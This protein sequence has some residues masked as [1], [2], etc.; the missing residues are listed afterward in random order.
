MWGSE[1]S[2]VSESSGDSRFNRVS[3]TLSIL[4]FW[5]FKGYEN[6]G[7]PGNFRTLRNLEYLGAETILCLTGFEV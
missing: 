1:E 5:H 7:G 6:S 3:G 2:G 4:A